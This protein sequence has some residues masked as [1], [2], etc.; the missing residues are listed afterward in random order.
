MNDFEIVKLKNTYRSVL[1]TLDGSQKIRV[2]N[3]E[4]KFWEK[5][6][7]GH[8]ECFGHSNGLSGP[9]RL[10]SAAIQTFWATGFLWFLSYL[11]FKKITVADSQSATG[12]CGIVSAIFAGCALNEKSNLYG[13]WGYLAGLFNQVIATK[14]LDRKMLHQLSCFGHD[15]LTMH[16][17][18]HKSFNAGFN[19]IIILSL[20]IFYED[21]AVVFSEFQRFVHG[22]IEYKEANKLISNF[23]GRTSPI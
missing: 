8:F 23:I 2:K 22:G 15:C 14:E 3:C 21:E 12:I 11:F 1:K 19:E 20:I 5:F 13:K 16:M 17:W 4:T 6:V 9:K 7:L 18:A 10:W